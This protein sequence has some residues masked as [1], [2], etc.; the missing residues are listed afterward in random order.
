MLWGSRRSVDTRGSL[1]RS[2]TGRRAARQIG[3]T[4]SLVVAVACQGAP[5][6]SP[7]L[8]APPSGAPATP[9][10]SPAA[11]ATPRA[12][13]TPSASAPPVAELGPV[14]GVWRI[15]KVLSLDDRSALVPGAVF[16]EE[17]YVVTPDCDAEPC[18]SIEVRMTPLGRS[19]PVSIANLER[20]GNRYVSAA[21]AEN[22]GPCLDEDGDPIRGGAKVASIMRLW[23][24]TVRAE[25]SAV[26]TTEMRGSLE[27]ELTPTPVGSAAGCEAQTAAYE[28][29][30]RR[31]AVAVRDAPVPDVEQ[32]PNTAG[33]VTNLPPISVKVTGAEI[34][35]FEIEGDTVSELGA[36][37]ADGGVA[38]CGAINY[39]WNEGDDRPAAC[40]VTAFPNIEDAIDQRVSGG[41]CT[42]SKS[43]I[44]AKLTIHMPRWVA[45]KRVPKR[46]LAWWRDV[47]VFIRDHE[48]GHVDISR[49]HVQRLNDRLLGEDCDD[50]DPIIGRWA[51][52]LS[53]AHEEF[54]RVEYAKPW[55]APPAG[56]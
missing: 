39:E 3:L 22:E 19:Q 9:S 20:D 40:A 23:L 29:S 49:D 28:L 54:D 36:S 17:A 51:K 41:N 5:A 35:Y 6:P 26:E 44:R 47:V 1:A 53:S 46:L 52:E 7:A 12:A 27:L 37:L 43:T 11:A 2:M 24:S 38:S 14:G 34:V 16:D 21:R 48:A 13:P 15:R 45:P 10:P 8:S 30:G 50:A 4:L 31:E 25:G 18:P 42:I 56:Y 32:E 55:P 33:G